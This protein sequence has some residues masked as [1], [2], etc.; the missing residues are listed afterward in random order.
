MPEKKSPAKGKSASGGKKEEEVGKVNHFFNNISVAIIK[1]G[2]AIAKGD[3][4]HFKGAT[5]DFTQKV[6]SMQVE[7]KEIEKANKG[8][9]FG[10]KVDDRV[11]EGD[12]VFRAK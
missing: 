3:E 9:E 10:M 12:T 7:K 2:K 1:A 11:R 5:S 4:L 8:N 6:E